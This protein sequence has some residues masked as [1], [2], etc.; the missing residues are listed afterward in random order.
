MQDKPGANFVAGLD[1]ARW[2]AVIQKGINAEIDSY[3][4]FFDNG[5]RRATGMEV[6]LRKRNVDHI[7]LMGVATEYCVKYTALDAVALGFEVTLVD[8]AC[9]GVELKPG[10][11]QRAIDEM[12]D[13]GVQIEHAAEVWN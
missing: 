2:T 7:W 1:R 5:K 11:T 8:D 10:D 4:G 3:S 12:R 6:L 13:A 9:R